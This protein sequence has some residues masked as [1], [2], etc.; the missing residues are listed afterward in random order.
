[1]GDHAALANTSMDPDI[2]LQLSYNLTVG[3]AT[4][5]LAFIL[6]QCISPYKP[7]QWA[8][9]VVGATSGTGPPFPVLR[10]IFS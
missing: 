3:H 7:H 4:M 10:M 6:D 5:L 8:K 1:M 9:E 2:P